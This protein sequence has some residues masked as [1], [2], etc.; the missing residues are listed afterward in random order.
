MKNIKKIQF[1]NTCPDYKADYYIVNQNCDKIK[2]I[3]KNGEMDFVNW[4]QIIKDNKVIAEIKESVCNVFG[5]D[6]IELNK[7][8]KS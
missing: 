3:K 2:T 4:F 5:E 7:I 8:E 6:E 1:P